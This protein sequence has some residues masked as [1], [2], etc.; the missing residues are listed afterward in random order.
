MFDTHWHRRKDGTVFPVEVHTSLYWYSGRRFLLKIARDISDRLRAEE[1]IRHSED[2][3]RKVIDTIPAYAWSAQPDGTVDFLNNVVW[4]SA[5]SLSSRRL[6]R[7]GKRFFTPRTVTVSSEKIGA[8]IASGEAVEAEARYRR[9]DGQYRWLL[10]R[11]V[12]LR[13]ET[14]AIVKWY[15][16]NTD[17]DDRKRAEQALR[18]NEAYLAE[19]QRLAHTGSWAGDATTKPLY[20]SEELFRIYGLDPQQGLPTQ[21]QAL[22]RVHPEDRERYCR[23]SIG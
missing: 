7:A 5:D 21:E 14:G 15:G 13:N 8:G 18:R 19:S 6:A 4:N 16:T 11:S 12:P 9:A 22:E 17:I 20:W 23:R 2:Q 10:C 3:L 1:A